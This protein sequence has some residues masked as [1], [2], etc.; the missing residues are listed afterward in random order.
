M[1]NGYQNIAI[2]YRAGEYCTAIGNTFMGDS[3]GMQ[4]TTGNGNCYYGAAAGYATTT[5]ANNTAV[6]NGAG[7]SITGGDNVYI[8]RGA[9]G[10]GGGARSYSITIGLGVLSAGDYFTTFGEG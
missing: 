10:G 4:A 5:A 2:G 1:T 9:V 3:A 7:D 8:G 6:G